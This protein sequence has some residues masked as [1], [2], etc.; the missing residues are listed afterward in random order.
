MKIADIELNYLD[1]PFTSHTKQHLQY[2]L[3][4]W[5]IVQICRIRLDNNVVG[6]GESIPNYTWSRVPD[7]IEDR[8]LGRVAGD[9]LWDD[10]LGACVQMALFDAVAKTLG[11][12]VYRLLGQKVREWCPLSWWA[13]DMAP[14]DWARQCAD[15]VKQCYMTAKLKARTWFDVHAALQAI[16]KVVPQQFKLDLDFNSTLVNVANAVEFLKTLERYE[17]V[18]MIETPIPQGDVAGNKQIRQRINRPLAMHYGIPPIMTALNQDVADGF[19]LCSGA[20]ALLKQA[21][22]C[23]VANKPFWLQLV[24]TGLTTAWAAH[25]GAVCV[26]AKWPAITCMNIWKSQL[27]KQKIELRGGFCRVPE[28]P[29]LGV[30]LDLGALRNYK[31]DYDFVDPP[32]HVYR[33]TRASGEVAYYGGSKQ[34]FHD[35]YIT[36]AMPICEAGSNLNV[37]ADDGSRRFKQLYARVQDGNTVRRLEKPKGKL[38]HHRKG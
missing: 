6:W 29:G 22:I 25:L 15:A 27:I 4:H 14:K 32:K 28:D 17:Q 8:I 3:P 37:V 5:R 36:D 7:D 1:V 18:S 23:E 12:P 13:M 38:S 24:G 9:L 33:Y 11:V 35:V 10:T 31:V 34:R 30:E 26:Q 21:T 2:W 16:I 20:S 19:V